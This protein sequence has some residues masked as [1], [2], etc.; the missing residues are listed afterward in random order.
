[1]IDTKTVHKCVI[2]QGDIEHQKT[3][4]G[5]VFWTTGQNAWPVCEGQCC[6][7]CDD[8]VVLPMRLKYV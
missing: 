4:Q 1:M 5:E 3:P 2:C 8:N 6:K 7:V